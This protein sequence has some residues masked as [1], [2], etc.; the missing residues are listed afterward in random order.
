MKIK[1]R[2]E[3]PPVAVVMRDIP[4]DPLLMVYIASL[5]MQMY[6]FI[7]PCGTTQKSR[8][9]EIVD[10]GHVWLFFEAGSAHR[11]LTIA[12]QLHRRGKSSG[13]LKSS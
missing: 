5:N 3:G 12:G 13:V 1:A 9:G 7:T 2:V 8:L 4:V 11:N 6:T 10:Y